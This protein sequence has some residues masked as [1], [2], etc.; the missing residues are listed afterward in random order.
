MTD[1]IGGVKAKMTTY[2]IVD[3]EGKVVDEIK[4]RGDGKATLKQIL[5]AANQVSAMSAKVASTA[6]ALNSA[7]IDKSVEDA[8][9]LKSLKDAAVTATAVVTPIPA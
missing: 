9:Y 7:L 8:K 1:K 3:P 4:V 6:I 5:G 2:T